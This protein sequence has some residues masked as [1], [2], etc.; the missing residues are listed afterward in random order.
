LDPDEG[1][2]CE[3]DVL[4]NLVTE[5]ESKSGLKPI[6]VREFVTRKITDRKLSMNEENSL[7]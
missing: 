3:E 6:V 2:F 1:S 5:D 7:Q 4:C